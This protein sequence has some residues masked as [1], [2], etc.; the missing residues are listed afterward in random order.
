MP[1]L[2]L[3]VEG[4]RS[5]GDRVEVRRVAMQ[6]GDWDDLRSEEEIKK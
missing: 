5:R 4:Y 2:L 6:F 1:R 3:T